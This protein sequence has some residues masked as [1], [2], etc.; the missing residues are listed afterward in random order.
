VLAGRHRAAHVAAGK[1]GLKLIVGSELRL[2]DGL[3]LA[4]LA[5]DRRA[6]GAL[7]SLITAGRRRMQKG[8]YSLCREDLDAASQGGL[9]ALCL[10]GSESDCR[11]VGE[12]FPD[13]SWLAVE[14]HHEAGDFQKWIGCRKLRCAP[15]CRWW[16]RGTC[17]C[18]RARAGACRTR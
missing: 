12:K 7:S 15:G 4:L 2:E 8:A 16:R 9:L 10:A 1:Y 5:P 6:Y 11:W 3:K 17:T 13:R 14:L 18:M